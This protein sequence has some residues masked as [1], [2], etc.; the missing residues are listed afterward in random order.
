[1]P[2]DVHEI[3]LLTAEV[4]GCLGVLLLL[5]WM[6]NPEARALAWWAWARILRAFAISIYVKYDSSVHMFVIGAANVVL[7]GS[8]MLTWCG[9]R[10]FEGRDALAI[11]IATGAALWLIGDRLF[12]QI[13]TLAA[14]SFLSAS[15]IAAFLWLA[16]YELARERS[17][18]LRLRW[19]AVLI[20]FANGT[21]FLLEAPS[22]GWLG[23]YHLFSGMGL[24]STWTLVG[25]ICTTFVLFAIVKER[26]EFRHKIGRLTNPP[27]GPP[28][29][30]PPKPAFR[31][32]QANQA[33]H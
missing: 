3:F 31:S 33:A 22:I 15:L 18:R 26:A 28:A 21:I 29:P 17:E 13:G 7:F 9:A 10:E 23:T 12:A 27:P 20:L 11:P 8:Y 25:A 30:R 5:L 32:D 14:H 2:L 6:Q 24:I 4:E 19:P 1:M 16:A